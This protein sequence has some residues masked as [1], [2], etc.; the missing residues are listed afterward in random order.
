MQ[1]IKY[2]GSFYFKNQ[3][4][5]FNPDEFHLLDPNYLYSEVFMLF[6]VLFLSSISKSELSLSLANF[7]TD[8]QY[9]WCQK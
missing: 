2:M 7:Q 3:N 1:Y 9:D 6:I 5:Y 8:M 4:F